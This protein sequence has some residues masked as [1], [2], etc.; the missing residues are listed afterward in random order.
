[1]DILLVDD[2]AATRQEIACLIEECDD[3]CVAGQA[4]DGEQGINMAKQL[5][6]D[7]II[8]DLM[9]PGINGIEATEAVRDVDSQMNIIILSNHTG[10]NIVDAAFSAGATGYV[11][12]D[13]AY[14]E[15]IPA[16]RAVAKGLKHIG[17][18]VTE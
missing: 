6:P 10:R 9:M 17:E 16:I 5:N 8:M 3:L 2:H 4:A 12:K 11:R 13:K 15:L 14:E 1:M 7:V 18:Q